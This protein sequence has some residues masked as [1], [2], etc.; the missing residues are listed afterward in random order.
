MQ[1]EHLRLYKINAYHAYAKK[2]K[3]LSLRSRI[4]TRRGIPRYHA[5]MVMQLSY[6]AI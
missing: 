4:L 2:K 1:V 6:V 5:T 3:K